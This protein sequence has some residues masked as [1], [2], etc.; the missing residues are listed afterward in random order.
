[1]PQLDEIQEEQLP[2]EGAGQVLRRGREAAKMS[3][4]QVAAETRIPQRHLILIEAGNFADLPARTY[5]I[6]FSRSY[7]KAVGL[8][9]R[10]IADQVRE[11]LA[12]SHADDRGWTS[13]HEAGDPARIPT[14][15]LAWFSALA[16]LLLVVGSFAYF[17]DYF[18][19]G[20]GPGPHPEA[21]M[22]SAEPAPAGGGALA[23]AG[24]IQGASVVFTALEGGIWVKFYD[25]N[26]TRLMEKQMAKGE[27]YV[28][29][30]QTRDPLI[31]TG[32]PDALAITVGGETV[33][34][35]AEQNQVIRDVAVSAKAL[36]A[37]PQ[38]QAV[39]SN[40]R[41]SRN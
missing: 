1:M 14:R 34:K 10:V 28:L 7:A 37:R 12:A 13:G 38:M 20:S 5:A 40:E 8:D 2:L 29:P 41:P 21:N 3:I 32:R 19:P 27:R 24:A 30:A 35:L 6:G 11:E 39:A 15:R 26:G 25:A 36:L 18:I 9:D 4:A 16:A 23:G 33:P 17:R 22:Q 31:W